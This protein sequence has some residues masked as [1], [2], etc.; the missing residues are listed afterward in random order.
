MPTSNTFTLLSWV[1][2]WDGGKLVDVTYNGVRIAR[3]AA[4]LSGFAFRRID[5]SAETWQEVGETLIN[6]RGSVHTR[7][8]ADGKVVHTSAFRIGY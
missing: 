4:V 1:A 7:I 8:I 6:N 2:D 3:F 5:I